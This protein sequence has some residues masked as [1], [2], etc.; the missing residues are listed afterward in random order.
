LTIGVVVA[1]IVASFILPLVFLM[2]APAVLMYDP[3]LICVLESGDWIVC[4]EWLD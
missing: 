1:V 4:Y 3:L 2:A